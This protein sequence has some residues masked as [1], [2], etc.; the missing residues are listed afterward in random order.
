MSFDNIIG[1][2]KIKEYLNKTIDSANILNGYLFVGIDGIGK[3][4]IAKEFAK[5]ILCQ[6]ENKPCNSCKSCIEFENDSNPDFMIIDKDY[7]EEKKKEKNLI[8]INQIRYMNTKIFE[9]PIISRRKVYIIDNSDFMKKEAQNSLL[10]TLEEPPEYATIILIASNESKLLNTIKSRC[11]KLNFNKLSEEEIEKYFI[12][13]NQQVINKNIISFS[14]G[15]IGKALKINENIEEYTK[16]EKLIE[17]INSKNLVYILNNAEVLYKNKDIVYDLLEY[18]N[19]LLLNSKKIEKIKCVKYVEEAKNRL[20]LNSNYDM[21]IDNLLIK[22][23]EEI[24]E[25]YSRS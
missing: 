21:T 10:K 7:D 5:M 6:G 25:K 8:S 15:S 4:L 23:W 22:I 13:N 17:D 3:K 2:K 16:L 9:K 20:N 18:T 12:Q 1:N 11:I 19:V 24:N 14:E